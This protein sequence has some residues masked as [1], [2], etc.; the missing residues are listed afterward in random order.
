VVLLLTLPGA[1]GA[2]QVASPAMELTRLTGT[3]EVD[4]RLDEEAWAGVPALPLT[5]YVPVFG[6][7]PTQRSE[8][9]VGYDD[10]ALFFGGWF[11]DTDPE[12]IR[13]NSLY[14]DRWNGDDALAIY[15]DAFND[16]QSTKWF[17]ITPAGMRFDVLVSDDGAT[18]NNS[19]DGFWAA[20]TRVT[21][22][23]WF[24]EVRIPF[25]TLGFQVDADGSAVMGLTATRLVSRLNE[26][27]TFPAIDPAFEFRQPSKAQD[28]VVRGV[29]ASHA[30]YATPYAL[31]GTDRTWAGD[32]LT[33]R[34]DPVRSP[35]RELGGDLR[36][37]PG[38]NLTVDL[39]VNT[40]F[41]Q[42]EADEQ[43]VNLDRFP[44]FFPEKRR[45]FQERS[46]L[47][48]FTATGGVRLFHSRRIGL[49]ADRTPVPVLGGARLVGRVGEWN[50][51]VLDMRTRT[52]DERPGEN[53]SVARMQRRVFNDYST[54]GVL[55]TSRYG[56]GDHDTSVG[57]DA[58]LRLFG[59]EYLSLRWAGTFN[60]ADPAGTDVWDRSLWN[61]KWQRRANRGLTYTL[62]TA[63]VGSVFDP[64]MGFLPRRDFTTANILANWFILND[65]DSTFRRVFPGL[66]AFSTFR[67]G[68]GALESAQYA[69]WVQWETK[70]GAGG[71][72]EPKLFHESVLNAFSLDHGVD[73]PA[74]EYTYAD[75]QLVYSMPTGRRMRSDV[76]F[77]AGTFF[78]GTRTQVT[79]TP[80]WNLS[81]HL[82]VGGD[83]RF[84]H[85]RFEER[86]QETNIHLARL[87]LR[88][89]LNARASGNAFVQYNSVSDRLDV[90]V[91]LR[92]NFAE[93]TDLWLV[94]NEGL[95]T[96]LDVFG[97]DLP[98]PPRSLARSLIVK[99]SHTF[100][101]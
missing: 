16:N 45:F 23:G 30:V 15:L 40:D 55:A 74:G 98:L 89:A 69:V 85:L 3:I 24:V 78:D 72:I 5:M 64:A 14:R 19:W 84:S 96:D 6:G 56:A 77:R 83:Y 63:R 37:T 95:G 59:D 35:S 36:Y 65:D 48:D 8:I 60:A 49:A 38:T 20:R 73:V 25:S 76:D 27:V 11:Y 21:E 70:A 51:G 33:G 53:Y 52:L 32:P 12:G 9:R 92:Y 97:P 46:D 54:L 2:G 91:R 71:W 90:N 68:D 29:H 1:G 50:V 100:G 41:A 82:E 58:S 39:T 34:F 93:G 47:F 4:G 17:G 66:L 13:I 86:D 75:L 99:Y 88:A 43:Q 26:R 87:R 28:V 79:L 81:K 42:V 57:T 101:F 67:N 31:M 44:L 62:E 10:D 18:F 61:A 94:Y 22:E 80:T 7:E